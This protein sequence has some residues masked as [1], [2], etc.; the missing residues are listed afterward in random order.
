[1]IPC[2]FTFTSSSHFYYQS[3]EQ[4]SSINKQEASAQD[5]HSNTTSS[6]PKMSTYVQLSSSQIRALNDALPTSYRSNDAN[7]APSEVVARATAILQGASI[8][9]HALQEQL[10]SLK[11]DLEADKD[12]MEKQRK[13]GKVARQKVREAEKTAI[14]QEHDDYQVCVAKLLMYLTGVR[15]RKGGINFENLREVMEQCP[16]EGEQERRKTGWS[17]AKLAREIG[18]VV[19]EKEKRGFG[20]HWEERK[21]IL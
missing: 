20:M 1:V 10:E 13:A 12:A 15:R 18:E 4:S 16:G 7:L 9:N 17:L 8:A 19:P 6:D 21:G 5:S 3:L 14:K 11:K 2:L